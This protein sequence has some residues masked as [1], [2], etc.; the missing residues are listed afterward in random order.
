MH[1]LTCIFCV[2][3]YNDTVGMHKQHNDTVG[4]H[5]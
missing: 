5:K 4:M 2:C 3:V 1:N